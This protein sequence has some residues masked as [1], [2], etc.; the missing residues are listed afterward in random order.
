M[1]V[2]TQSLAR[3]A[4]LFLTSGLFGCS[5]DVPLG[6]RRGCLFGAWTEP[7]EGQ[8][9]EA[10]LTSFEELVGRRVDLDREYYRWDDSFPGDHEAWSA[11]SGRIS[12]STWKTRRRDD[13]PVSW[14]S[15]A[16]GTEDAIVTAAARRF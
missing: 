9:I 10:A 1:R 13:S 3:A 2:P 14:A 7:S 6:Q 11:A 5:S 16:S 15:I 12:V 8:S 4:M